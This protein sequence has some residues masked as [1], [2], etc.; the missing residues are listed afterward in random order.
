MTYFPRAREKRFANVRSMGDARFGKGCHFAPIQMND[1]KF[2]AELKRRNVYKVAH[3]AK[4][5]V[6]QRFWPR[7]S[8]PSQTNKPTQSL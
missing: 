5:R 6:S 1:R 8:Q 7:N 4:I 3:C 2:F